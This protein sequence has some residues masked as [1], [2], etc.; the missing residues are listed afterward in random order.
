M[1]VSSVY[2]FFIFFFSENRPGCICVYF[3]FS[4]V[5][6]LFSL[7]AS[8]VFMIDLYLRSPSLLLRSS[9]L[10]WGSGNSDG[11]LQLNLFH[12]PL[13]SLTN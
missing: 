7:A 5:N 13:L 12:T 6:G 11:P 8:S 10:L 3:L 9:S 4:I 2:F 1:I